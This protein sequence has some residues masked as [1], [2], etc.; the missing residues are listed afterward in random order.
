MRKIVPAALAAGV[1]VAAAAA[2]AA[3]VAYWASGEVKKGERALVAG[4]GWGKDAAVEV[5]GRRVKPDLATDGALFI[6]WPVDGAA[7]CRI[8]DGAGASA[9][10]WINAPE[11]WFMRGDE[12]DQSTPGG[13]LRI[14]GRN[15]ARGV[16]VAFDGKPIK[17]AA[18]GNRIHAKIPANAAFGEHVITVGKTAKAKWT[19]AAPRRIWKDDVFDITKFGAEANH[20]K[21]CGDA[22]RAALKAAE[23]NGGGT[24]YVPCGRFQIS[25]TLDIP[26]HVLL[27]GESMEK[28]CIYWRDTLTPPYA[29]IRGS[30]SFGVHELM[31]HSGKY[32]NGI[33]VTNSVCPDGKA[34]NFGTTAN[35]PS[36]DVS[37]KRVH[38]RF[39]I[40]Q[41]LNSR[42]DAERMIGDGIK[43]QA[44]TAYGVERFT[45]EDCSLYASKQNYA[46]RF[47]GIGARVVVRGK[48]VRIARCRFDECRWGAFSGRDMEI[49]GCTFR[50]SNVGISP[51]VKGLYYGHNRNESRWTNDR[52]ALTH[53]QTCNAFR[54][55]VSAEFDGLDATLY[56]YGTDVESAVKA[57]KMKYDGGAGRWVGRELIVSGGAGVGQKRTITAVKDRGRLTIDRPFDVPVDST[58]RFTVGALRDRIIYAD[59]SIEDAAIAIQIY[60]SAYRAVV[61][62]NTSTRAGG[63]L[64]TGGF[65]STTPVW[66]VDMNDNLIDVGMAYWYPDAKSVLPKCARIG[67][68]SWYKT[69]PARTELTRWLSIKRN[70]LLSNAII[71]VLS[72]DTLVEGNR[73]EDSEF[74]VVCKGAP[75]RQLVVGNSFERVGTEYADFSKGVPEREI[76]GAGAGAA[77]AA[78][79]KPPQTWVRNL[80][81]SFTES[82]GNPPLARDFAKTPAPEG[83]FVKKGFPVLKPEQL[84]EEGWKGANAVVLETFLDVKEPCTLSF[85]RWD[86]GAELYLDGTMILSGDAKPNRPT[87]PRIIQ[88]GRHRLRLFRSRFAEKAKTKDPAGLAIVIVNHNVPEGAYTVSEVRSKK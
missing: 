62:R 70:K 84:R 46:S 22:V 13:T 57:G 68:D 12:S 63:F 80:S 29:F 11:I 19:V 21:D 78:K 61:A 24:V 20:G 76:A 35:Y 3:P 81:Y 2:W 60:G 55:Q 4:G 88:P 56:A 40:D 45:M 43:G 54:E 59:N 7:A 42:C 33:I 23:D 8:V 9:P 44:L 83:A 18:D 28:S 36:H 14:Y 87:L 51:D 77:D 17:S 39:I 1:V 66:F 48:G 74:G 85:S 75:A 37:L 27:R 67:T 64:A 71:D 16:E 53:D 72:T 69:D 38:M 50:N 65:Y 52:E 73:V 31:V 58:S 79:K 82:Y 47:S 30:H 6:T 41:H 26:P 34:P 10:F 49:T 15:L 5:A 25:G 86:T 32:K